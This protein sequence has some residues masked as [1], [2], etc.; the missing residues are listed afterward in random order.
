MGRTRQAQQLNEALVSRKVIGQAI[1]IVMHRFE[2]D[3]DRAFEFLVRVS[4]DSHTKLRD[5]A[6][7]ITDEQN[8]QAHAKG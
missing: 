2:L 5:V 7:P 6:R 8:Q 1:G 4:R 3:E